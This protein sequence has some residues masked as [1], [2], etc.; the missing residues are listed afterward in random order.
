M[1][2]ERYFAVHLVTDELGQPL[3]AFCLL[4]GES[5]QYEWLSDITFGPFDTYHDV[6]RWLGR[7]ARLLT[8]VRPR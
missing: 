4:E 7:T 6:T 3:S 8:P 5:G 1:P 2:R